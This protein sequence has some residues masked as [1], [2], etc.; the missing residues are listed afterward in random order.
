M[1]IYQ[2]AWK[3]KS[4][5]EASKKCWDTYD[6]Q[7]IERYIIKNKSTGN[8]SERKKGDWYAFVTINIDTNKQKKSSTQ[9]GK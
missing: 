4:E 9:Y 6:R 2:K 7:T 1:R 8:W 3:T 5:P